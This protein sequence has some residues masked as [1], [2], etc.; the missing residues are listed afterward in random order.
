MTL[1]NDDFKLA[2]VLANHISWS[3]DNLDL[4]ITVQNLVVTYLN[5]RGRKWDLASTPLKAE[6]EMFKNFKLERKRCG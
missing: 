5:S 6:L 1:Q 3:D 2:A 4:L